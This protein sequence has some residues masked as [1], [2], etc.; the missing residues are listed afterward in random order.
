MCGCLSLHTLFSMARDLYCDTALVLQEAG[1][2]DF[3]GKTA[4]VID[5]LRATSTMTTAL[6]NGASA[7]YPV[8][9]VEEAEK[10]RRDRGCMLGGERGGKKLPGFDLGNSPLEYTKET[11]AEK[12]IVM[13]TTNG[14]QA[15]LAAA[16]ADTVMLASFLNLDAVV[17]ACRSLAK[18]VVIVCA[19]TERRFSLEDAVC[20]GMLLSKL[21]GFG[22]ESAEKMVF[23]HLSRPLSDGGIVAQ[24][25]YQHWE[26]RL[27]D[28]LHFSFHGQR[29]VRLGFAEDLSV[30]AKTGVFDVLP[31]YQDGKITA[32]SLHKLG[33]KEK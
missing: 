3:A 26:G 14:T 29:L 10:L 33:S 9:T 28:M 11:V 27:L 17:S 13:T 20:A 23:E 4:V 25:L 1:Q 6:A 31:V 5:I 32:S 2:I 7:I 24:M 22:P 21:S 8:A 30:C 16:A 18:D 15:I 12:E 19:G